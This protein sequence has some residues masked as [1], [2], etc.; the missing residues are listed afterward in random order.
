MS[1]AATRLLL[2]YLCSNLRSPFTFLGRCSIEDMSLDF[3][4]PGHPTY[5]LSDKGAEQ[6]VMLSNLEEYVAA[7]VDATVGSG[8]QRQVGQCLAV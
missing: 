5:K 3:T 2:F 1:P 7:V 4:L 6:S 8:I